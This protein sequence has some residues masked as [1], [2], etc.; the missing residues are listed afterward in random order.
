MINNVKIGTIYTT[1]S[2]IL[3]MPFKS[4][5]EKYPEKFHK[6]YVTLAAIFIQK[7]QIV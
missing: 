2:L 6:L 1:I 3:Q 4:R 7:I 5:T